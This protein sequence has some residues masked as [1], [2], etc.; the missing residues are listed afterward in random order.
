MLS[1]V[2]QAAHLLLMALLIPQGRLHKDD[3]AENDRSAGWDRPMELEIFVEGY[4]QLLVKQE[5]AMESPY[6]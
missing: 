6:V 2:G 3:P 1:S 4:G 5:F